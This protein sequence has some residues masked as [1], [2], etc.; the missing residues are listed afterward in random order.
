MPG[1]ADPIIYS[2][3]CKEIILLTLKTTIMKTNKTNRRKTVII[4]GLKYTRD[5]GMLILSESI[6]AI[7]DFHTY[8]KKQVI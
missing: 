7:N 1:I 3:N 8:Q 4:N 6:Q 2:C 5:K